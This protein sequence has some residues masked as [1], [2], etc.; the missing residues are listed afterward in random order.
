VGRLDGRL[1]GTSARCA[2]GW[3]EKVPSVLS[4]GI[5]NLSMVS[6]IA[7]PQKPILWQR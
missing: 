2:A 1:Q 6:Q 5:N 4:S 3:C 7:T